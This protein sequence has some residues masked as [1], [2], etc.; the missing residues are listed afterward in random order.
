MADVPLDKPISVTTPPQVVSRPLDDETVLLNL[1]TETY[2]GLDEVGT[3]MLEVLRGSATLGEAVAQ[4]KSEYDV[5]EPTLRADL[6][7]LLERLVANGLI[8]LQQP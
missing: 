6:K 7:V 8:E 3:R 5:D 2:F 4:L 1:E